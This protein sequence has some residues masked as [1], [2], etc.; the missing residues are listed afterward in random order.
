MGKIKMSKT[1]SEVT[2][3]LRGDRES[4]GDGKNK[5]RARTN[6]QTKL[7][8]IFSNSLQEYSNDLS[9]AMVP[10]CLGALSSTLCQI[11]G[12]KRQLGNMFLTTPYF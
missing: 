3:H 7:G 11:S 10:D 9:R 1:V 8:A 6:C 5:T 4:P 2:N 12:F